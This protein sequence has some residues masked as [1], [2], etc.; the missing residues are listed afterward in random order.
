MAKSFYAILG[1]TSDASNSEIRSAYRRL[2]KAYHPDHYPGSSQVFRDI[3]EAYAVLGDQEQRLRYEQNLRRAQTAPPVR[4]QPQ[5]RPEPLI[6]EQQPRPADLGGI[7]PI[8]SFRTFTPSFD[9]IFDWLWHH[10][11]DLNWPKSGRIEQLTLEV[12]V[13]KEQADQGGVAR[14]MVPARSACPTCRGA[15][16][17]GPYACHRCAGEGA[18]TGEIPISVSFPP[19]I[20][21][22]HAV[23][24][25][26]DRFGIPNLQLTVLFR[27]S[28]E[29]HF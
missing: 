3:Q 22:D 13:T 4:T 24:M 11:S 29:A 18:I 25:P 6:P 12:P 9:A 1:I 5:P 7:S 17:I 20:A 15:G 27:P 26:L 16:A 2:A 10:F 21:T 28:S 14:I 23:V 8:R 19:G